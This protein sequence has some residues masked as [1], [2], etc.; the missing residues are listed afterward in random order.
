MTA[1]S[2]N[3]YGGP[4]ASGFTLTL[5]AS[6]PIYYTTNGQDPRVFGTG[7]I[8]PLARA[9]PVPFGISQSRKVKAALFNAT[10][11]RPRID[12]TFNVESIVP[13]RRLTE[14]MSNPVG[15]DACEFLELQNTGN[16]YFGGV[17]FAFYSLERRALLG[18]ESRHSDSGRAML[19]APAP[20][21]AVPL[22][23]RGKV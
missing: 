8:A 17:N 18:L 15:G 12:V 21:H 19:G 5:A 13:P 14:I 6:N 4:V 22:P 16:Y 11:W 10:N 1:P 3:Q 9:Y 2:F 23:L 7:T 20:G